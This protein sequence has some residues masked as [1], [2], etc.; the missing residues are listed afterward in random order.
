[1]I[2]IL[3][4]TLTVLFTWLSMGQSHCDIVFLWVRNSMGVKFSFW[5]GIPLMYFF[6]RKTVFVLLSQRVYLENTFFLLL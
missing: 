1:M 2:F 3:F 4:W 5:G 6:L